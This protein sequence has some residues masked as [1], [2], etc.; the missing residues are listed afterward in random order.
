MA[1][2]ILTENDF[3]ITDK[4]FPNSVWKTT[5]ETSKRFE[6]TKLLVSINSRVPSVIPCEFFVRSKCYTFLETTMS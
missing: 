2:P 5:C 6:C 4:L 1:K 3:M